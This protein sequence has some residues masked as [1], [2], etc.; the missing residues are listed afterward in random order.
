M[1]LLFKSVGSQQLV[2]QQRWPWQVYGVFFGLNACL[3]FG[4]W[5]VASGER[6]V[7]VL[8]T[9][10]F[11][12]LGLAFTVLEHRM[13]GPFVSFDATARQVTIWPA[14]L[15]LRPQPIHVAWPEIAAV[16]IDQAA[17]A[18]VLTTVRGHTHRLWALLSADPRVRRTTQGAD[19]NVYARINSDYIERIQRWLQAHGCTLALDA[20]SSAP[21]PA[22][23]APADPLF[24]ATKPAPSAS[25][26]DLPDHRR[27]QR[28]R[29]TGVHAHDVQFLVDKRTFTIKTLPDLGVRLI[30]GLVLVV[31]IVLMLRGGDFTARALLGKLPFV[32]FALPLLL[33]VTQRP[34][35]LV[36]SATSRTLRVTERALG[37]KKTKTYRLDQPCTLEVQPVSGVVYLHLA[38]GKALRLYAFPAAAAS[39]SDPVFDTGDGSKPG[40]RYHTIKLKQA[41]VDDVR[42]LYVWL[43]SQRFNVEVV[44][45]HQES[46][47]ILSRS[48]DSL[49]PG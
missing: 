31:L 43:K 40:R 33:I 7:F 2:V 21:P 19:L 14:G 6:S 27:I 11:V 46:T 48:Q 10:L 44:L 3:T 28:H 38:D 18:V 9:A 8:V 37:L 15:R 36:F 29:G 22:L 16:Q 24:A 49:G 34:T 17:A 41:V 23:S 26:E 4:L 35:L 30:C 45:R 47:T 1:A 32:V 39:Y 20:D 42:Q 12:V 5:A 13:R 25:A